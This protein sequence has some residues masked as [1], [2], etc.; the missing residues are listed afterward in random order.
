MYIFL[1]S[2]DSVLNHPENTTCEFVS[3]LPRMITVPGRWKCALTECDIGNNTT[4]ALYVYCVIIQSSCVHSKQLP[5]LTIL[6]KSGIRL[7]PYYIPLCSDYFFRVRI[8]LLTKLGK[9][10]T[11]KP[12]R[13][14]LV[15]HLKRD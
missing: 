10:P 9:E 6:N 4:E 11:I 7:N 5:I 13:C 3:E 14:T 12:S 15:L 8:Q 1:S 2:D